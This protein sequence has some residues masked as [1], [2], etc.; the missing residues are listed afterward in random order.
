M[1]V[2]EYRLLAAFVQ[3]VR[4]GLTL[5][6]LLQ[7][8]IVLLTVCLTLLLLGVGVQPMLRLAPLVA[9]LYSLLALGVV[10]YLGRYVVLPAL[11]PVSLRQALS[12]IEATYPDLHDDLTN[13]LQLDP[14]IL[15]RSNPHGIA[16]DLV[17][18]LHHRTARQVQHYTAPAVVR[19]RRLVGLPWCA[20]VVLATV[21][22][23]LVQPRLLGEAMH[24][25]VQPLSYLPSREIYI[26]LTPEHVT[27]AAGMNFEVQAQ[28]SGRLP[29]SM[30]LL[31]K[32]QGQPDR[33]YPMES[34]RQGAFRY[35]FLKPQ[36]SLTF[37]AIADSFTS[38]VG[39][40][41]VVPAPAIGH[42]ALQY[43]F[44]D[45]TGLPARTQ[46]GGGDIQALPGT[47]VQLRMQANV[48]LTKGVLRFDAGHEVPLIIAGQ[49]LHGEMLVM[50]EGTYTVEVEDTHGLRNLQPPRY[51]VQIVPDL[52]PKVTISQPQDGLEVDEGTTLQLQY[53]AEDDFGLQDAI[54]VYSS[55]GTAVQRIP[56]HKG[57]F[58]NRQVQET[59]TWDMNQWPLPAAETVQFYIEVYDN[60]T[61]SGPKK[62]VSQVLTLKVHSRE[63]EHQN[64]EK[65]QEEIAAAVLDLL[66]D[67][68]DLAEQLR[69]WQEQA[70]ASKPTP[71]QEALQQARD[72]QHAAMERAEQ[73]RR[74]IEQA[75]E[76]VQHDPFSTYETFADMQALQRNMA[77]LQN[78][79][80]PQLQQSLQSLSPQAPSAA[81]L[82]PPKRQLE[83]VVQELERLSSLAEHITSGEKLNDVAQLS[84]KLLDQQNRLLAALDNLPKDF[85]GGE[86]P[87]E[88]QK[89]LNA[90]ESLMQDL[91]HAMAQLPTTLPDEFLNRQ[92]DTF[93][94]AD[95]MRQL[96]EM[97][98]KLAAGDLEG[99]KQM[100][101]QLLKNLSAMVASLQN[102][103]QQAR[104]G[105]LDAMSQQLLESSNKLSDLVRRQEKVLDETQDIDQETLHKLNEAQQQ[106]LDTVQRRF[107]QE[108]HDLSRLAAEISRRARQHPEI[109]A[110]LQDAYQ[111]LLR[112]L[113]A[114][115][116]SLNEHD[117]QQMTE[118]LAETER[119]LAW[120]QQRTER[121]AQPDRSLQQQVARAL[122]Q[123][124]AAQ[125]ALDGLP[126][127]RQAMLTPSQR[128][129]LGDLGQRQGGVRN[130]TQALQQDMQ[131][132][133]PLMPF[134]PAEL[135]QQLQEA[136]PFM[137]E[138]QGALERQ[139]SQPA[140]PAEQEALERLR[141]AENG[142]QQAMQGMAQRG[143]MMGMSLPM[144]RQAGRFPM[145][146]FMPQ[147]NVDEQQA[148][149]A[150]ASVRNF[151]LPD[152]AAYKVP[153]MFRED[154]M[155]ALKE[156][157]PERF[158]ELI[159]Q[160]YRNI[161][162]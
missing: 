79:L 27:I 62:G 45:Y 4:R 67:H 44:P 11:R 158:K 104:G 42:I 134:L 38:A 152:K 88:L 23:A 132:L 125:Q 151:Q 20:L 112:Q 61:I 24:I 75:M 70:E 148:G 81:Q 53:E 12:S 28:A 18:A 97:K 127:D 46:E 109:D 118:D 7:S 26:A 1:M 130:D 120:M 58:A 41:E 31:V 137:G 49:E 57:H 95:M 73:L 47:Q 99:A 19:Q 39:T 80:L 3:R 2:Q 135:G 140:I 82:Q 6:R 111:Q 29:Q 160:Y 93:P 117:I 71:S 100:A 85:Q 113:D 9:P 5:R 139:R 98:Q 119:Q 86:L 77:H 157:Y 69:T 141:N 68:L 101:A 161:V 150:G 126:Q 133:L 59:F 36:A 15:A 34:V 138:A 51:T 142:L 89:M 102:M 43:L 64:L 25:L 87:P 56:L 50:Q 108:L 115:R 96:Q 92:L 149:A 84:N 122:Q 63:Q 155:E 65:L 131:R 17:Q 76:Y 22:V 83:A 156:G 74:Q 106:A 129:Q 110:A 145:P 55:P 147:P 54:L 66:A 13:A 144:L 154:I 91:M 40:L 30:Q 121:L 123:L 90:L 48:P 146:E 114:V 143:Q 60:D 37:Q 136:I 103:R 32:R 94:L 124:Q 116:K 16:L 72:Q 78:A 153:R 21:L 159:E 14:E 33:R 162:R 35:T 8:G 52:A 10:L 128:G 105:S 107:E